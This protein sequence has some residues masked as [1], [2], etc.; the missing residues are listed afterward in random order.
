[1]RC[2]SRPRAWTAFQPDIRRRCISST[3]NRTRCPLHKTRG[4]LGTR[5]AH[6]DD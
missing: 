6:P 3:K 1:L 5:P 2:C 4:A